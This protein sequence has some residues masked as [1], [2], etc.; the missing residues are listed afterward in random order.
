LKDGIN[1]LVVR[2]SSGYSMSLIMLFVKDNDWM[3]ELHCFLV[4]ACFT[5][6]SDTHLNSCVTEERSAKIIL[7]RMGYSLKPNGT[8]EGI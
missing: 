7:D 6:V 5:L 2:I 4:R 8:W 3:Y 1:N